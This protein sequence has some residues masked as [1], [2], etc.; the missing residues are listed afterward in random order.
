M[1][2]I[3]VTAIA[4]CGLIGC[5]P[6]GETKT[7]EQILELAKSRF[8]SALTV[9]DGGSAQAVGS[10]TVKSLEQALLSAENGE[11]GL[12]KTLAEIGNNLAVLTSSSGFTSRPAMNELSLQYRHLGSSGNA[13]AEQ[14]KLLASRT[15]NLLASELETTGFKYSISG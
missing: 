12:G 9:N 6:R 15:Y 3:I 11:P 10:G 1:K 5:A 14:V 13:S 2:R 8:S 4:L 7:L